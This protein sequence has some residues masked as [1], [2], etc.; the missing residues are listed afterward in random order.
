M[1]LARLEFDTARQLNLHAQPGRSQ[2]GKKTK[3]DCRVAMA[4]QYRQ[5]STSGKQANNGNLFN[6]YQ[7]HSFTQLPTAHCSANLWLVVVYVIM[8]IIT[9]III[10]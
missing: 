7:I 8:L 6:I 2:Q 9:N 3:P 4:S 10:H 5:H 1:C